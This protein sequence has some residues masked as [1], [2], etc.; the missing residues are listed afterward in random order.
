MYKIAVLPCDGTGPEVVV[1]GLKVLEVAAAK[2]G[3]EYETVEYD[4]GGDRYLETGEIVPDSVMAELAE[5]DAIYLG[6]VGHD[7]VAPGILEKGILLK[8]GSKRG[9]YYIR[10]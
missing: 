10:K 2:Y 4:I 6:A 8:I 9:T 3:V 7:G 1:E 5:M